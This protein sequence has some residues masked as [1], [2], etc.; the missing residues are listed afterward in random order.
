MT[1]S[2]ILIGTLV[3]I[4]ALFA[5]GQITPA[6]A[7][8]GMPEATAT[9][10]APVTGT[11]QNITLLTD[12]V[13]NVVTVE[14]TYTDSTTGATS[15]VVISLDAAVTLGLVSLDANGLPVVNTAM[16]DQEI[17]IDPAGIITPPS[18][19][20]SSNPVALAI[21]NFFGPDYETIQGY[22]EEGVG[23]GVIAQ[24]CWM[25]YNL[26]GDAS[27]CAS[28]IEARQTGDYSAI[29]LPDGST[30][31]NWG[32]FKKSVSSENRKENLGA[33][34][35]GHAE[36]VGPG[37]TATPAPQDDSA[38]GFNSNPPDNNGNHRNNDTHSAK[39]QG[40]GNNGKNNGKRK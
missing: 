32:Q 14:L 40:N 33:I 16:I 17:T 19:T 15:T 8:P 12:E 25:S 9:A 37:G 4:A 24:A 22:H 10:P 38:G 39:G 13:T 2:K 36:P 11:I 18:E 21:A 26:V 7:A 20:T 1:K 27:L 29:T 6:L 30:P 28:I 5:A 23:Y 31:S 3:L 34:M 35:S